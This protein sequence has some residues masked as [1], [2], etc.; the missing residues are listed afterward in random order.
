MGK[1]MVP[2]QDVFNDEINLWHEAHDY[3][4]PTLFMYSETGD[5]EAVR[6]QIS[7]PGNIVPFS[8]LPPGANSAEQAFYAAVLEGIPAT[9]PQFIQFVQGPLAQFVSGAFPAL[10]GGDT[11]QNDTARGI[12]V[13]RDQAMGRMGLSWGSLQELF[14]GAYTN[15]VISVVKHASDEENFSYSVTDKTGNITY[16]ELSIQDLKEG[17]AICKADTDASF[18]ES[19]NQK[20]QT[21]QL[22]MTAAERNPILAAVMSDPNN[23]EF[24]HN[25][26]GLSDLVV[27]GAEARNKQLIEIRQLLEEAPI[28]PSMPEVQ[29]ASIQDPQLL[30][31]MAE[32]EQSGQ[33][34][35]PPVPMQ[36]FN[37]SISIDQEFDNHQAEYQVISDWLCGEERRKEESKG[38]NAGIQNVRLHGLAHKKAIPPPPMMSPPTGKGHGSP[39]P[40]PGPQAAAPMLESAAPQM[41]P[42]GV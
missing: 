5:I 6:E 18:P 11:G 36:M 13:Q 33:G 15:A 24:G 27:P 2:L 12:A 37:S 9:L 25:I 19:T 28:P 22:M 3:C 32:W 17:T 10:F 41:T 34:G 20:R 16:E 42:P 1:R 7:E 26:L 30:A 31:S 8:A 23:L 40:G 39:P 38:N 14:A 29:Q 4:V 21:Y 35:P